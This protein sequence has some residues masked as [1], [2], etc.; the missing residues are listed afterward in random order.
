VALAVTGAGLGG[1]FTSASAE[2]LSRY[3]TYVLGSPLSEVAA[4]SGARPDDSRTRR[5][6]PTH[7]QQTR[8]AHPRQVRVQAVTPWSAGTS[9]AL[10]REFGSGRSTGL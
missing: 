6:R 4:A 7:I 1:A 5:E 2:D 10:S 9:D 8:R 3:R